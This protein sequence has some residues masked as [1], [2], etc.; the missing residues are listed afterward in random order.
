MN[1]F[2]D[3]QQQLSKS[4]L[5][6]KIDIL[7]LFIELYHPWSNL[8]VICLSTTMKAKEL[9]TVDSLITLSNLR[10][11]TSIMN[12]VNLSTYLLEYNVQLEC[13]YI[14]LNLFGFKT[15]YS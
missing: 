12:Q 6:N 3:L 1:F 15:E 14:N 5:Q 13:L 2:Q 10:M 7:S 9:L 8:K 4:T 11:S